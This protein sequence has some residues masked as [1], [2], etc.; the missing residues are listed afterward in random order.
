MNFIQQ[1]YKGNN[2]WWRWVFTTLVVMSPFILNFAIYFFMPVAYNELIEETANF[3]G[4][5]NVFF[6]QNLLPFA[7]LLVLLLLFVRFLHNRPIT[8]LITSRNKVAWRRF[9]FGFF[10]WFI[11]T[12][13]FVFVGYLLAPNDFE[14]N[15][16]P[17][18]FFVLVLV[19]LLLLPL[20]TSFEELLFRGYL[21][22]GIG[23]LTKTRWIPLVVT[24]VLFGVLHGLNPEVS[25]L[26]YG[27]LGFY[28]GTGFLFGIITLLDEGTELAL[29]IHAANNFT[30]ATLAT[31]SWAAFQTDALFIDHSEPNLVFQMLLPVGVIY[32]IYLLLLHKKYG[33]KN[34]KE[35]LFGRIKKPE[36]TEELS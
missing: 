18:P 4:N 29:G 3:Q 1:A 21:L 23:I 32:P 30:A 36:I 6:V 25:K 7:V 9:F 8:S 5:K 24:S 15:F 16:K 17:M 13:I 31:S 33:W 27:I 14:W 26:G 28:I 22:Q 34:W 35:K 2:S 11:I 20:Q 12:A 19:S 10:T